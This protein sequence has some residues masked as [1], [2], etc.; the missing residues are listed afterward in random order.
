MRHWTGAAKVQSI[1][2]ILKT[3]SLFVKLKLHCTEC[4]TYPVGTLLVQVADQPIRQC[5]TFEALFTNLCLTIDGEPFKRACRRE[6]WTFHFH[7]FTGLSPAHDWQPEKLSDNRLLYRSTEAGALLNRIC[8]SLH[9]GLSTSSIGVVV[10]SLLGRFQGHINN[11][12]TSYKNLYCKV[13][14]II[15]EKASFRVPS[16]QRF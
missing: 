7:L 12:I 16:L 8:L 9:K 5:N 10:L 6:N 11:S 14:Y 13:R 3:G 2:P 1:F 15:W 4:R